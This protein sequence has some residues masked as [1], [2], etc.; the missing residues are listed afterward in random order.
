MALSNLRVAAS[1]PLSH[2]RIE[3]YAGIDNLFDRE[4]Y[5]NLRINASFGRYYEPG[6]GRMVYAGIKLIY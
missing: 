4:Y 6:P 2:L 3:P 5:D 1:L